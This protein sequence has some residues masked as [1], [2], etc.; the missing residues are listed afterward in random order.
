MVFMK[1]KRVVNPSPAPGSGGPWSLSR[2]SSPQGAPGCISP[3]PLL[4]GDSG[5]APAMS[6]EQ[7]SCGPRS[8]AL[9]SAGVQ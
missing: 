4:E 7:A 3:A 8:L 1:L 5:V 6:E 2:G 9:W